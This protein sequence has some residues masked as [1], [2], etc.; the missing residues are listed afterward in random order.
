MSDT[1]W[2]RFEVFQQ[3]SQ[4]DRHAGVGSVHAPDGEMALLIARDVFVRRPDC[5][6]LWV[7]PAQRISSFT[8]QQLASA[9]PP[10]R[11]SHGRGPESF[12][13]FKKVH[14]KGVH[15][16]VGQVTAET[17][18]DALRAACQDFA[19]PPAH[20]WWLVPSASL[21]RSEP[22]DSDSFFEPALHKPFRDQAFYRT[23][24]LLRKLKKSITAQRDGE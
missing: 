4:T 17:P 20:V 21:V 3:E 9:A 14:H 7:A 10:L 11:G 6:S 13:V 19:E 12:E 5:V 8:V 18:F 22:A 1:Q 23:Q 15:T 2:P 24:T 16:H